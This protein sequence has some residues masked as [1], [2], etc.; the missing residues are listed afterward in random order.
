M[1]IDAETV[2]A[3]DP[4][5]SN[6][7]F[8]LGAGASKPE[9]SGIPT[10]AELLPD[11]LERGRRLDREDVNRLA[12]FCESSNI[13]NIE[14]LLTAAHLAEYC[15]Q[16]PSVL[17]LIEFLLYRETEETIRGRFGQR[18]RVDI[19]SVTF[20]RDTLQVL[21][22][23]LSS[24]ML[25]AK[26][27]PV[28]KAIAAYVGT[29]DDTTIIT[30]NYD[31]CIDLAL[32]VDGKDF[33]YLMTFANFKKTA[34]TSVSNLIKLHGSLN[35]FYCDTCQNVNRIDI[36]KAIKGFEADNSPYPIIG[37]CKVCGGQRRGL[38]IPPQAMKFDIAP[39]LNHLLELANEHL[40][41][42]TVLVV[43]GYSF[44]E[45][46]QYISRMVRKWMQENE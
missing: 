1:V 12:D 23:L 45:A 27:N 30:T 42:A 17:Q 22:G 24:R 35:W 41:K 37:V 38:L 4:A 32:G 29:R 34:S 9:P 13:T 7:A 11:L 46:D 2:G 18:G 40:A 16:N 21:F 26:P 44:A 33:D 19:G 43:V 8:L 25:P 3:I 39:P 28:H 14:D 5:S 20:L 36:G 10:V 6:I 31:C 15:G